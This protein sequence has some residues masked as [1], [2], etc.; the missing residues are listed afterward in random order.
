MIAWLVLGLLV[1]SAPA[2]G[3]AS[4]GVAITVTAK[5]ATKKVQSALRLRRQR[6]PQALYDRDP[7]SV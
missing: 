5:S 7:G 1:G 6:T 2:L 4:A 3:L